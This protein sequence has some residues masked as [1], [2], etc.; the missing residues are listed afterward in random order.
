M[1]YVLQH[2][3]T[4]Q[5]FTC[6]L[7]NHYGLTYYGVK[8]WDEQ[9]DAEEQSVP[10]LQSAG[11]KEPEEWGIILLEEGEMKLCNVKLR[12]D[13]NFLLYWNDARKPEVRRSAT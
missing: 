5:I 1:P 9:D 2:K 8:F 7:V 3:H 12:N 6:R 13:P 11:I 10:F 4:S